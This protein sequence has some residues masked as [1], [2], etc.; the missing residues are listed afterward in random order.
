MAFLSGS[1]GIVVDRKYVDIATVVSCGS[2]PAD[3]SKPQISE[4]TEVGNVI[5]SPKSTTN[6]LRI[7]FSVFGTTSTGSGPHTIAVFQDSIA[8][9]LAAKG[10]GA[11]DASLTNGAT[12]V[13]EYCP[14][15]TSAVT[16]SARAGS[17]TGAFKVNGN[18]GGTA[19]YG[20]VGFSSLVVEELKA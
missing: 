1:G 17:A 19:Y 3:N 13:Y 11:G 15:T 18:S 8:D 4:G 16:I 9:A 7:T 6:R 12:L 2:I 14:A 20:G 5:I 10:F